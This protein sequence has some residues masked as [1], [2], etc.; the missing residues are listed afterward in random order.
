[1]A[2]VS[3]EL[4]TP[5]NVLSGYVETFVDN[6]E[7]PARINRVF[8]QM[9]QQ[10]KRMSNLVND[11]LLLS[12]LESDTIKQEANPINMTYLLEQLRLEALAFDP[13]KQHAIIVHVDSPMLLIGIEN[14]LGICFYSLII[15]INFRDVIR[16]INYL[17]TLPNNQSKR[18]NPS[19]EQISM[20]TNWVWSGMILRFSTI[21][22]FF[23]INLCKPKFDWR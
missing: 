3:H 22:G 4:R 17:K 16:T 15:K 18:I 23:F 10:T 2:N 21:L 6:D 7:F 12:R 9:Q 1:M 8:A 13:E 20:T 14:N 11:L 5:L 19:I